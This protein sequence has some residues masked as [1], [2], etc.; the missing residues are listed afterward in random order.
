MLVSFLIVC[1]AV[2]LGMTIQKQIMCESA[3][4]INESWEALKEVS[5]LEK[6]INECYDVQMDFLIKQVSIYHKG[7]R[8][9]IDYLENKNLLDDFNNTEQSKEVIKELKQ[10]EELYR[11]YLTKNGDV[12]W[13]MKKLLEILK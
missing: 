1:V 13:K 12:K 4:K 2:F 10:H 11:E 6:D 7:F 3:H 5:L 9:I 8:F